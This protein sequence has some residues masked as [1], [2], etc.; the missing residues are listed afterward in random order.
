MQI[1]LSLLW[2]TIS[3]SSAVLILYVTKTFVMEI[4][5]DAKFKMVTI[6]SNPR[7]S[8]D[9]VSISAKLA[10]DHDTEE[11]P[12]IVLKVGQLRKKPQ[13]E[14]KSEGQK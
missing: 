9:T 10:S 2:S 4:K 1:L 12:Q 11:L 8:A 3:K 13:T 14:N 7:L 6:V 5:Y